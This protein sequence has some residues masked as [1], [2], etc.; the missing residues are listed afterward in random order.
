MSKAIIVAGGAGYIGSQTCKILAEAG[1]VPVTLDDLSTG[2]RQAVKFGPFEQGDIRDAVHVAAI[3]ARYDVI[4]AM[5][6]AAFSLVGESTRDPGK[7]Y[8]NNVGAAAAFVR[9]LM[10]NGVFNFVFSSTAAVYG[11]PDLSPIPEQAAAQ[12]INPYGASKLAFEQ[13]LA[14]FAAADP[15]FKWTALRYFN[16]A[17]A[18]LMGEI[19]ESHAPETHLIPLVCQAALGTGQPL[20]VFGDDY[21]T[22]DGTPIRDYVHVAD[23]A[24]A[25]VL[26]IRRMIEGGGSRIY[27]VGTGTGCTVKQVIQTAELVLQRPVPWSL[28]PRRAGDPPSL[29]AASGQLKSELGWMPRYS[30]LETIVRTAAR[31]QKERTY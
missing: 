10:A 17:G 23:L 4:G 2:Y 18:D 12:P 22:P 30:D 31:W 27:N 29:V 16:A 9:A 19:G 6:F 26:A 25:H 13:A 21:D 5:H 24:E 28:G 20:T 3:C 7:Y 14:W 8:E 15:R 11:V 1:F